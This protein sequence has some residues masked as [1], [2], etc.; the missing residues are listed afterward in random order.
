MHGMY[1]LVSRVL[2]SWKQTG[3]VTVLSYAEQH[4]IKRH[5]ALDHRLV[6]SGGG[7]SSLLGRNGVYAGSGNGDVHLKA[8]SDLPRAAEAIESPYD[9]E[10]RYR[11]R[12]GTTWAGYTVHE[13]Q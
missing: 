6:L 12:S 9:E 13:S 2:L 5:C 10:A 11:N 3:G 8:S 1:H 4:K 7:F